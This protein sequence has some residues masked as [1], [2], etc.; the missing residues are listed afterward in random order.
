MKKF[1]LYTAA[2]LIA[3]WTFVISCTPNYEVDAP[4]GNETEEIFKTFQNSNIE[5]VKTIS[6]SQIAKMLTNNNENVCEYDYNEDGVINTNDLLELLELFGTE[7]YNTLQLTEFLAVYGQKYP[8][9]LIIGVNNWIQD[10]ACKMDCG[11]K[12]RDCNGNVLP[13]V[14]IPDSVKYTMYGEIVD[15]I[16]YDLNFRGYNVDGSIRCEGYQPPCNGMHDL[17]IMDAYH[18]GYHYHRTFNGYAALANVPDTIP[19]CGGFPNP[20][21]LYDYDNIAPLQFCLNCD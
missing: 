7:G 6:K 13:G 17:I 14:F 15:S 2:I 8:L 1:I 9:D 4:Y 5:E 10:L 12:Q 16:G 21:F 18:N 11:I 19:F 3:A 20:E